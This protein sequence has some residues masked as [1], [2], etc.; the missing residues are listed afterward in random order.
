RHGR[1]VWWYANGTK[2]RE[3]YYKEGV[4]DGKFQEWS[5]AGELLTD[6]TYQ[7]GRKLGAR[8][9]RDNEGEKKSE[10]MYLHARIIMEKPDEWWNA[11][12]AMFT[13]EGADEKQGAWTS[14]YSNGQTQMQGEY[15]HD[16]EDGVF[17][18]WYPNGQKALEGNY[19]QG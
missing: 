2:M 14:W 13:K 4:L 16:V 1:S 15:K 17:T 5:P 9:V 11:Q 8:V 19:K 10:G 3:I 18:W 6:D 7:S 12:P